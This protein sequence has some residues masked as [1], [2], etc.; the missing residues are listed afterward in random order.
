LQYRCCCFLIIIVQSNN[1][2]IEEE[3]KKESPFLNLCSNQLSGLPQQPFLQVGRQKKL[4]R[5][6]AKQNLLST[7]PSHFSHT[8]QYISSLDLSE[9][10][11][12]VFSYSFICSHN[13]FFQFLIS[14]A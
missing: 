2:E 4:K 8:F 14:F 7:I 9:N 12:K 11:L 3:E 10:K 1:N 13:L 6:V 5:F